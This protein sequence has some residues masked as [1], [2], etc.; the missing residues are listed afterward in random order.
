ML[1]ANPTLRSSSDMIRRA[2]AGPPVLWA[3]GISGDAPIAL[4]RIDEVEDSGIVREML[5]AHEYW[6][7]K[8]LV[9]D[10]VIPNER[11][12]SHVQ[13]LQ[14]MLE[15]LAHSRRSRSLPAAEGGWHLRVAH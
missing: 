14:T 4:A 5:R 2:L 15:T 8:G 6:R 1:Y 13:D 3:Q 10:L 12:T 7:L 9:V 11:G